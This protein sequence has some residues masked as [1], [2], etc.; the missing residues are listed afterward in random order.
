MSSLPRRGLFL[1]AAVAMGLSLALPCAAQAG[2]SEQL[3][4]FSRKARSAR[5][6]FAQ[7]TLKSGGQAAETTSGRFAFSK[8]G[9]FRWEVRTPYEQLMVADG[10]QVYFFDKDLNQ[11]T[12]RKFDD[13]VGATPA[14]ILFGDADLAENFVLTDQPAREGLDW[15]E[16]KPR[17][18]DS[19]FELIQIGLKSGRPEAMEVVDSF[20]RRT[21]FSFRALEV[22]PRL[23]AD[24]F[25]FTPPA[26]AEIVRQ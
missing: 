17:S 6:E 9:L 25:R 14:A 12:I 5:G 8:P 4:D 11:V 15:V 26:G 3:R 10:Q 20:G 22:N 1:W 19:G 24:Q 13:S 18:K 7:R 23:P 2:A 21:Q 16:A